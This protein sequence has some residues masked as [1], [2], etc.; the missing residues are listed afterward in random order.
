M[1]FHFYAEAKNRSASNLHILQPP[2]V[3]WKMILLILSGG[4]FHFFPQ[5]FI[6]LMFSPW[7][8]SLFFW[9]LLVGVFL[10]LPVCLFFGEVNLRLCLMLG[11]CSGVFIKKTQIPKKVPQI[12][13]SSLCNTDRVWTGGDRQRTDRDSVLTY[14]PNGT[15]CW[16]LGG[17]QRSSLVQTHPPIKAMC[18]GQ[19]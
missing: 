8:Y 15:R 10:L 17:R 16:N 11:P 18:C 14:L 9:W 13:V 3:Q 2:T 4:G 6:M 12:T 1:A 5:C 19:K 7:H